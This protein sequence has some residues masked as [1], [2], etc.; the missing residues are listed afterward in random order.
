M[1][2]YAVK[3]I[4]SFYSHKTDEVVD[5]TNNTVQ[6]GSLQ[7]EHT[8]DLLQEFEVWRCGT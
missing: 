1:T 2:L 3:K 8:S 6:Q 7:A 4:P 5:N